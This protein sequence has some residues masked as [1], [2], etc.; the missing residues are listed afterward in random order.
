MFGQ[1]LVAQLFREKGIL[2]QVCG[3]NLLVLK[4][5]PPLVIQ[6]EQLDEFETAVQ[7]VVELMH[8]STAFWSEAL[9]MARRVINL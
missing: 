2:T 7:Q 5:A 6:R 4:V 1:V 9:G 8:S 3:N